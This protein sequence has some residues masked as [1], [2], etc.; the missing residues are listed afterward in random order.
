MQ[1]PIYSKQEKAQLKVQ[2]EST[3]PLAGQKWL[4]EQVDKTR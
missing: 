3:K 2:I 1:L 4:L